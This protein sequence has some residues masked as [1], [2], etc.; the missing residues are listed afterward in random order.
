M[1]VREYAINIIK[2]I[3]RNHGAEQIDT[4]VFETREVLMG[5]YGEEARKLIYDLADTGSEAL[6]LRYDLTVPFA[7][8]VA[9]HGVTEMKRFHI[10]KVY[11]RDKPVMSRGRFCEFTQCDLDI[12]GNHGLL[13]DDSEAICV[14][15]EILNKIDCG[16]YLL[17][18][19][20]RMLLDSLLESLGVPAE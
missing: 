13:V 5:K 20:H 12:T 16:S 18:F 6:S 15:F 2:E 9:T 1:A 17:H 8:Y 19:N 11:R 7:R 10:G 4:P 3:F 14:V